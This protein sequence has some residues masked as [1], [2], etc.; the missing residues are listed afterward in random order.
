MTDRTLF[1]G[2]TYDQPLD[3]ERLA[4]QL[5]RVRDRDRLL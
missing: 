5:D 2:I 4:S 1:D 3:G